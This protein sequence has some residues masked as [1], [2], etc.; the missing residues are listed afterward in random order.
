MERILRQMQ[1]ENAH[2][3]DHLPQLEVALS[4]SREYSHIWTNIAMYGPMLALEASPLIQ[5][6][7]HEAERECE[8]KVETLLT[9]EAPP[10]I[11]DIWP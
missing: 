4:P 6:E 7:L 5:D 9:T 11:A 10:N 2:M 8:D 1:Q 3:L